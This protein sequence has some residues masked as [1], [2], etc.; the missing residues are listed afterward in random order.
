MS[1]VKPFLKWAGGKG[2]LLEQLL[3]LAPKSF[4]AYHEPFVGGAALF[5]A[6]HRGGQGGSQG[7]T[8]GAKEVGGAWRR[9]AN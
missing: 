9:E 5:F 1:E 2:Q 4:K 3:V 7:H 8:E 6:L